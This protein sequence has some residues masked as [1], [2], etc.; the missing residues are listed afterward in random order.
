MSSRILAT[1]EAEIGGSSSKPAQ[2]NSSL[3]PISRKPITKKGWL[4]GGSR[5]R[6]KFKPQ[7]HRKKKK[8]SSESYDFSLPLGEKHLFTL[9]N[10]S[11]SAGSRQLR[12]QSVTPP[13]PHS[14]RFY[15]NL[16]NSNS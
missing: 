7:Y 13:L 16:Q 1:Q 5:C 15:G 6:P 10:F 14:P 8:D 3:D 9:Q 2:A 4:V 12:K 11:M